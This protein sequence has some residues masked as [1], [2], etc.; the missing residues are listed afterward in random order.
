MKLVAVTVGRKGPE[1]EGQNRE[2]LMAGER[3]TEKAAELGADVIVLPA[4]FFTAHTSKLRDS[5][6][7]SLVDIA[8]QQNIA[9]VFGVDQEVKN[10]SKNWKREISGGRLPFYGYAWSPSEDSKHCWNQ[11]STNRYDQWYAPEELCKEVRLLRIGD[12]TLA[13]LMCG[14]IFSQRIRKALTEYHPKPIVVADVAHIGAGFRVTPGMKVLAAKGLASV[15][16][17]HAQ[18]EYAMKYCYVPGKG[19][20][21]SRIPDG[22]V[23]GPPRIELKLWTF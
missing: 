23:Y 15:C 20:M 11:R 6:A 10:L 1:G 22:H 13:V 9:V 7:Y 8:K 3:A 16:S 12:E 21:S 17:V 19:R 4:G 5:I 18:R 14:E 2:R